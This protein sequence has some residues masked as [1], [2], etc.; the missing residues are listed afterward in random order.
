MSEASTELE[1][2]R[3]PMFWNISRF[4]DDIS[5]QSLQY[6][7]SGIPR[8][9]LRVMSQDSFGVFPCCRSTSILESALS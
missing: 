7:R 1:M 4:V 2:L 8:K 9:H 3:V 5:A 6:L